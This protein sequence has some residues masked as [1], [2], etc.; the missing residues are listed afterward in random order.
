MNL[1][2]QLLLLLVAARL[3]GRLSTYFGQPLA[4]GEILAGAL[5]SIG[6]GLVA[7][8]P[9][10]L[11]EL[12]HSQDVALVAEVGIF[13]LLLLTG[14]EMKPEEILEHSRESFWVAL[15][16][17]ILPFTAGFGFAW[18]V[19]PESGYKLA[20]AMIVG[21]GLAITAIPVAAEILREL[22][23]LHRPVGE[24]IVAAAIFDDVLGLILLAVTT[25]IIGTGHLPSIP[26]FALLFL[27]VAAF[28]AIAVALGRYALPPI[29]R[30]AVKV[31]APGIRLSTLLATAIGFSLLALAFDMHH[32]LGAFIAGLFFSPAVVGEAVYGRLKQ[33]VETVTF[34]FLAPIFFAWIGLQFSVGVFGEI[35]LVVVALIIIALL[36][37]I[38]GAGVPALWA[39][40]NR[41]DALTVG[42]GMTGR[43][44]VELVVLSVALNAGVFDADGDHPVVVNLFSALV[45]TAV[46]TTLAMP[47]LLRWVLHGKASSD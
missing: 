42:V 43:G 22:G 16:G 41:R 20:Q 8:P 28:F 38:F 29:W 21:T 24:V 17:A 45:V 2:L 11:A 39:G 46:V 44:A 37:K 26:D 13:F 36:G 12:A 47:V 31:R 33:L 3:L 18:L 30:R 7:S 5:L 4:F 19:L 1:A 34:G 14:V 15:G 32:V 35:P 27:K 6:I 9:Q 23:L 10:A 40:L 25:A